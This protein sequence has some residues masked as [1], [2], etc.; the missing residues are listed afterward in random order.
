MIPV[1]T[2]VRENFQ[3]LL[4]LRA[5]FMFQH[6]SGSFA[7]YCTLRSGSGLRNASILIR[8]NKTRAPNWKCT[9]LQAFLITTKRKY[10]EKLHIYGKKKQLQE[11]SS[12]QLHFIYIGRIHK[13]TC[14]KVLYNASYKLQYSIE[15]NNQTTNYDPA[16]GNRDGQLVI[17]NRSKTWY[18]GGL[19]GGG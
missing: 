14:L 9:L 7:I 3:S 5:S 18:T 19:S 2:Q 17:H 6:A 13:N 16:L 10:K 4:S 8:E 15:N 12:I 11:S 1:T